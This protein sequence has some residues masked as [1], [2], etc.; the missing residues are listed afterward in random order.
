MTKREILKL[1][2]KTIEHLADQQAMPDYSYMVSLDR[3][4]EELQ[5][6]DKT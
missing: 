3:L 1:A 2:I 4:R 5:K 6:E